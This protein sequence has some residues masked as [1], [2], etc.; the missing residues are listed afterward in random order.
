MT[1]I[2]FKKWFFWRI[3]GALFPDEQN[4][5]KIYLLLNHSLE[6]YPD[7]QDRKQQIQKQWNDQLDWFFFYP[8]MAKNSKVALSPLS[9]CALKVVSMSAGWKSQQSEWGSKLIKDAEKV[10]K[11]IHK[12]LDQ[13]RTHVNCKHWVEKVLEKQKIMRG[14][15]S[16][17]DS[18]RKVTVPLRQTMKS[19]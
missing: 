3:L 1:N 12:W 11:G 19:G 5:S 9:L 4:I 10:S 17:R 18:W 15:L 14:C 2:F 7:G 6:E 8:F 13:R 16:F